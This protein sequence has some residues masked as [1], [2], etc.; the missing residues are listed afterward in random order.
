[1]P[2]VSIL[3]LGLLPA[4]AVATWEVARQRRRALRGFARPVSPE[5]VRW[6]QYTAAAYELGYAGL[7]VAYIDG[8]EG[9]PASA[10]LFLGVVCCTCCASGLL[11][12]SLGVKYGSDTPRL[13]EMRADIY[14]SRLLLHS[15]ANQLGRLAHRGLNYE[16]WS[17]TTDAERGRELMQRCTEQLA[18]I[19]AA[20]TTRSFMMRVRDARHGR[21]E[22][23]I[24][25]SEQAR[26]LQLT[27]AYLAETAH[28]ARL[29]EPAL[30]WASPAA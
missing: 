13:T 18:R 23:R 12:W 7:A 30:A 29:L 24:L 21:S 14:R 6:V 11:L 25:R 22:V 28:E 27:E 3:A 15:R 20:L 26:L 8:R 5:G 19:Q 9:G 2:T 10:L 16:R 4:L 17:L 1:M